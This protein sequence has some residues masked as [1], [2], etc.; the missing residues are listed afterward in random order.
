MVWRI[1][2]SSMGKTREREFSWKKGEVF[3][4][5][6]FSVDKTRELGQLDN[7]ITSSVAKAKD[8]LG[9]LLK[10]VQAG[11]TLIILDRTTPIARVERIEGEVA[12]PRTAPPRRDWNPRK[13]LDLP[14][15]ES[16]HRGGVVDAVHEE[17]ESGW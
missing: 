15:G 5:G 9:S 2:L 13:V 14:A 16:A 11:E 3:R 7:M 10:Q 1:Q 4:E 6:L 12:I 17:R 8:R